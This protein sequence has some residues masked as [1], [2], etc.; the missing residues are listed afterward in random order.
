[1]A[2]LCSVSAQFQQK[3]YEKL[4]AL[5]QTEAQ[6]KHAILQ[7]HYGFV[8]GSY[9]D[10][11]PGEHVFNATYGPTGGKYK[12]SKHLNGSGYELH[13]AQTGTSGFMTSAKLEDYLASPKWDFDLPGSTTPV[14]SVSKSVGNMSDQDVAVMFVKTKDE[15][16]K[17]KG[18]NIK[19]INPE[20]DGMVYES[21]AKQI[22]YTPTEVKAK[23]DA[24]KASG[25]KLSALKKKVVPKTPKA[26]APNGVPTAVNQVVV[27]EA[28]EDVV[29]HLPAYMDEDVAKAYIKAKDQIAADPNNPFTLYTQNSKDFDQAI[30]KLMEQSY[31]IHL[32]PNAIKNQI[33]NYLGQG[34]KLSA[35]KKKMAKSGEY[36]PKAPTLKKS[37]G[38]P[39]STGKTSKTQAQKDIDDAAKAGHHP[40]EPFKFSDFDEEDIFKHLKNDIFAG[41]N[42]ETLYNHLEGYILKLYKYSDNKPSV[43]DVVRAYDKKKAASLGIDNGFFYEKKVA[44]YASSPAGQAKIAAQKKA[45]E[46]EKNLPPLP[47][48]SA[49]YQVLSLTDAQRIQ[50]TLDPWTPGER[51]GLTHYTGGSY[52][53]INDYLRGE[54]GY[55]SDYDRKAITNAQ[56]GMRPI[57]RK[58]LVHRGCDFRQFGLR[59]YEEA[60]QLVGKTVQD[61]GFLSTSVGGSAD[62]S[63]S[64]LIEAELPIGTAASYIKSISKF[65]TTES[66]MLIAAGTKYD[67]L[68]VTKRGYQTVVR[69]RAIPGSHTK[70]L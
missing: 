61:K 21:I 57:P 13:N 39:T 11:A 5:G 66:E 4:K 6:A 37:K 29:Q 35:L 53:Q 25:N 45:V 20:L 55:L 19:G 17:A 1:M 3:Q 60:L 70:G 8:K 56:K 40:G 44:E 34:N 43:L 32:P 10:L 36:Q 9:P 18:I 28:A 59:N 14:S 58:A 62:F 12:I 15:I 46:L 69:V 50:D 51:S 49:E 7:G 48:D 24:Y 42:Q 52:R 31:G 23:I 22:G 54:V 47:A 26:P 68:S 41:I 67:V 64:V 16:A 2:N 38:D 30:Y 33:A 63:G 65:Q 27:H